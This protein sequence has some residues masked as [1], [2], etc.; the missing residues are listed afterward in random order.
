MQLRRE[1]DKDR[2]QTEAEA[3]TT[4]KDKDVQRQ[5][6]NSFFVLNIFRSHELVMNRRN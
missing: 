3:K 1:T 4:D 2:R 6:R 5:K